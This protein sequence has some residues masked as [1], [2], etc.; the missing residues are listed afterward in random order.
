MIVTLSRISS[1]TVNRRG[2]CLW[3]NLDIICNFSPNICT[4]NTIV[5]YYLSTLSGGKRVSGEVEGV[6]AC[7]SPF[8]EPYAPHLLVS[9]V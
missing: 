9:L 6:N 3:P 4:K 7:L 5:Q 8:L 1:D 2:T